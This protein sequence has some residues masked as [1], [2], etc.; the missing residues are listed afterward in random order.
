MLSKNKKQILEN[1]L[2]DLPKEQIVWTSGYLAGLANNYHQPISVKSNTEATIIYISETGN[3]KKI[4]GNLAGKIKE[5]GGRVKLKSSEQYRASDLPKEKNLVLITSTHGEGEIPENGRAFYNY[6]I[7]QKPNLAN[8]KYSILA[9]GDSNYPLFCE[10]G[11]IFDEEFKKLG[12]S[13]FIP[14]LDLDLDFEEFIDGWQSQVLQGFVGNS[15]KVSAPIM[16]KKSNKKTNYKGKVLRNIILNDTHSN[17]EVHHLEVAAEN[18]EYEVG[19][20][21]A[22]KINNNAPRM[23]S[24][25]SSVFANENEAHLTVAK[26]DGGICSSYL[27]NLK[28]GD[29]LEFYIS[30][31]NNFRLPALDKDIIMV[32]P[33]TGVAPF[34]GFLQQRDFDCASGKNWL[35][36]GAQN[37]HS[38]FLYQSEWHEYLASGLLTRMDV[39]FSRNQKEKIYVQ[40]RIKENADELDSWLKEGAY[41]YICGDKKNMAKDVE[42]ALIEIVGKQ[43]LEVMKEEGRYL[44]DVY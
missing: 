15:E 18:L 9:L 34:R 21:L 19:D 8:L 33:G 27:A 12:A 36:F 3:S 4:A 38:D 5:I 6:L 29:E 41:F 17:K 23:Y 14:K 10:A 42:E 37:S 22:V 31:N 1:F 40:N 26:V 20:A 7:A 32:G 35:F 24:I 11:K 43:Y 16:A 2:A 44:R 30:K 13:N 28:A 39:A 25:A